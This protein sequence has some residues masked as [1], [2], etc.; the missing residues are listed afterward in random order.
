MMQFNG[1]PPKIKFTP[2]PN[3]FIN[4][5]LPQINDTTELKIALLI[6]HLLY[7]KRGYPTYITYEELLQSIHLGDN[8]L[9]QEESEQALRKA[10]EAI[11]KRG[12]FLHVHLKQNGKTEDIYMLNNTQNQQVAKRLMHG[13]IDTKGRTSKVASVAPLGQ[14][15][16]IFTLYEENIGLLTPMIADE[17]REAEKLYPENWIRDAIKEA[18]SQNKRKWKYISAILERWSL[19]GKSNGIDRRYTKKADPKK[20]VKGQYGHMVRH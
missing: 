13:R 19:E 3:L 6:F 12:I 14:L 15:P 10:L 20:Y 9:G 1:F 8:I 18:V 16:G 4:K 17:L 2:I 11:V 5:L 7:Q